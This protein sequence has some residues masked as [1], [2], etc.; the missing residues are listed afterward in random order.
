MARRRATAG[1]VLLGMSLLVQADENALER[2]RPGASEPRT[3]A[4]PLPDPNRRAGLGHVANP[5]RA[6]YQDF[7]ALPDRW[8]LTKDLGVVAE[9]WSDPYHRNLLKADRPFY[10]DW[11]IDVNAVSDS[12]LVARH[13]PTRSDAAGLPADAIADA[14]LAR[15]QSE[16]AQT[17][18][19]GMTLFQGETVFRPPDWQL[20]FG[21]AFN[22][23]RVDAGIRGLTAARPDAPETRD[24]SA[25]GLQAMSL[26]RHLRTVTAN[27]DFDAI[28]A[29]VQAFNVDPRGF[30]L[31]DN[32]PGVR[33]FGTRDANT[34]QYSLA[35]LRR[36]EKDTNSG[37]NTLD[38]RDEDLFAANLYRQD[39][40]RE[41]LI[42]A[43][44]VLHHR[45][46]ET[47]TFIDDNGFLVRPE[48]ASPASAGDVRASW[49]GVGVDGHIEWLN[50]TATVYKVLG[51]TET[52]T[53]SDED[54]D[55]WFAAAELSRDID[56][57]RLRVSLL[58]ASGDDVAGDD[59]HGGYAAVFENPL[60]AGADTS[61]WIRESV[62][63]LAGPRLALSRRN[64]ILPSMQAPGPHG[65]ANFDQPGLL[66]AGVGVDLDVLPEVRVVLNANR[67]AF[68]DAAALERFSG[69]DEVARSL[70]WDL[71]GALIYRPWLAQ[72]AILRLSGGVLVP[73]AGLRDLSGDNW[74]YAV[75]FNV[76]LRY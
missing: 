72:N 10:R 43:V 41:G 51:E 21:G 37:L 59:E 31:F 68:D 48:T 30:L 7:V 70:G 71:S 44:S 36:F 39:W 1:Y 47:G 29:G 65:R 33:L 26:R 56:W 2:R 61:V 62:P 46:R 57:T 75:Q 66:L 32:A 19:V 3:E 42:S 69:L 34:W 52:A 14:D 60:F 8:R 24:D 40:P 58:Y 9:H 23:N 27:Y 28:E 63:V 15:S 17:V 76:T 20:Q 55:G 11:F 6:D 22:V 45:D 4:A 35:W 64:A 67:L 12:S 18:L 16:V 73:S 53:G 50:I 74:L 25:F 49:L 54:I 5:T 13:A 38:V